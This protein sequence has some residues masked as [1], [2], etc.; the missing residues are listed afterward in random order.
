VVVTGVWTMVIP[1]KELAA[2]K[3]RIDASGQI[4]A[5]LALAFA[6]DTLAS[7]LAAQEVARVVLVTSE[8][9]MRDVVVGEPRVQ[10]VD[11]PGDGLSGAVRAGVAAAGDDGPVAVLLADLPALRSAELDAALLAAA[12][13]PRAMVADADGTGTTLLT[14]LSGALL[15][16]RFGPGSRAAHEQAGHVVLHGAGPGLRRDIDVTADLASAAALGVGP[17]TASALADLALLP[18]PPGSG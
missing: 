1:V 14:G 6:L 9:R 17:A 8:P 12:A 11:D 2:A 10:V 16:P 18:Q 15:V 5:T 4:R 3:S 13:H 7:V